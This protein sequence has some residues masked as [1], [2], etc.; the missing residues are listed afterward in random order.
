[1]VVL[2]IGPNEREEDL[3]IWAEALD[4]SYPVMT[5]PDGLV[6]RQ[7]VQ[8]MAF[9]SAAF[10]QDWVVGSDGTVIYANNGFEADEMQAAIER[11]LAEE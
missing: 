3:R 4:L 11:E 5:D 9:P 6:H 8:T 10:P 2:G 1:M 7:Y